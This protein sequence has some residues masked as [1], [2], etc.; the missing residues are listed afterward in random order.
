MITLVLAATIVANGSAQSHSSVSGP[1]PALAGR[2]EVERVATD[3]QDTLHQYYKPGDPQL[4]G[5][6]FHIRPDRVFFDFGR[7]FDCKVTRWRSRKTNWGILLSRGFWRPPMGGRPAR[8][9]VHDFDLNVKA[10]EGAIAYPL[11]PTGRSGPW[12]AFPRSYWAVP[13]PDGKLVVRADPQY[14]L[15]LKRVPVDTKPEAKTFSCGKPA[16]VTERTICGELDLAAWDRSL[17]LALDQYLQ[18]RP[19]KEAQAQKE[20]ADYLRERNA[21]GS[22]AAC[23]QRVQSSRV[24]ELFQLKS[25]P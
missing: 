4:I 25:L 18:E 7:D 11:C 22:D 1:P 13:L 23:I 5:R 24:F 16:N 17:A 9:N 21:C 15:V 20:Q 10:R 2:W 14:L 6:S 12:G 3:A 8:P 19:E